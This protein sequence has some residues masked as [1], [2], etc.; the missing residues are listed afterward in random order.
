MVLIS[1]ATLVKNDETHSILVLRIL[2]QST[3]IRSGP[4]MVVV[5]WATLPLYMG[6]ADVWGFSRPG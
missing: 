1:A 5:T 2:R 6:G 3:G 4:V